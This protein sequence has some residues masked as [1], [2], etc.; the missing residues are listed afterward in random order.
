MFKWFK[1][2]KNNLSFPVDPPPIDDHETM[3][4]FLDICPDCGCQEFYFGPEGG[5]STNIMCAKCKSAFNAVPRNNVMG[6]G[7]G[8]AHRISNDYWADI[9]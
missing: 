1:K 7:K 3:F 6:I 4:L 2:K 8:W 5:M 9:L